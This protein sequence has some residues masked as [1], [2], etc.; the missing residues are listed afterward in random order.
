M[1][2]PKVSPMTTTETP[3]PLKLARMPNACSAYR[4]GGIC[5]NGFIQTAACHPSRCQCGKWSTSIPHCLKDKL[6]DHWLN[7]DGTPRFRD[8][9]HLKETQP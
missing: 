3:D 2:N 8:F 5:V 1:E 7:D 9:A 4:G 6:P